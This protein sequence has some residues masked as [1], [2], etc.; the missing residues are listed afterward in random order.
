M[1]GGEAS[2]VKEGLKYQMD[3]LDHERHSRLQRSAKSGDIIST[4]QGVFECTPCAVC[5]FHHKVTRSLK[6]QPPCPGTE[7]GMNYY[8]KHKTEKHLIESFPL[9]KLQKRKIGSATGNV[10]KQAT[11][12]S[13]SLPSTKFA[14]DSK[15]DPE[16]SNFGTL[17]RP[18]TARGRLSY[19]KR[20]QSTPGTDKKM[21]SR[22]SSM[23]AKND[24]AF[25]WN[26]VFQLSNSES[27]DMEG[28]EKEID[29]LK[30]KLMREM[31]SQEEDTLRSLL[32]KDKERH[33]QALR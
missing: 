23:K 5:G 22:S 11:V 27:S 6:N 21:A 33:K 16:S 17:V 28:S 12:D 3:Q 13:L 14:V 30:R 7:Y 10:V 8:R 15:N 20:S 31:F 32:V 24:P 26:D 1:G 4:K 25:S 29:T 18:K 2:S 19:K 9:N